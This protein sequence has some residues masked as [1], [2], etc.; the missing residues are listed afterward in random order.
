MKNLVTC[1]LL[2]AG[3]CT[4]PGRANMPHEE[5]PIACR[6]DALTEAERARGAELLRR[7]AASVLEAREREDGYSFRYP[8]D[9]ALF[10]QIA[11]LVALEHRCCPFLDFRLEWDGADASP[12]LHVGGGARVKRFLEEAYLHPRG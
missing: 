4:T 10:A 3:A 12:W 11:E 9:P 2:L 1:A 7:H 6:L 5:I 8:S